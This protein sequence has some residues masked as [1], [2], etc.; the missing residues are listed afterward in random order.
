MHPKVS[1]IDS[2]DEIPELPGL[3]HRAI[4]SH[5]GVIAYEPWG[6]T[7]PAHRLR[8]GRRQ[9]LNDLGWAQLGALTHLHF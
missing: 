1:Q 2:V 3:V 4:D 8:S 6:A 7:P 9:P 5:L